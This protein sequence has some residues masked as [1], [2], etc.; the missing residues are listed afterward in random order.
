[1]LRSW[2]IFHNIQKLCSNLLSNPRIALLAVEAGETRKKLKN[3][4]MQ[5]FKNLNN[6]K[7]Q[8]WKKLQILSEKC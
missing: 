1:M 2:K 7:F 5:K 3:L 6:D 8:N 4:K